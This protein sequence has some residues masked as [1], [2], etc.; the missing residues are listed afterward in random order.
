VTPRASVVVPTYHRPD[1]LEQCLAALCGQSGDLGSYEV[2]VAD[3]AASEATRTQVE[4]WAGRAGNDALRF[5]YVAV[6][7]NHGPAAARNAGWKSATS[8]IIAFT[9]DD[10]LP[11]PGWLAAGVQAISGAAPAATGR[12]VVPLNSNPPT[13]YELDTSHLADAGFITANCFCRRSLLSEVGGFDERFTTAWREDSDLQFKLLARGCAIVHVSDAVVVHPV[14]P[15]PWGVSLR[16]QR[17]VQFNALLYKKHP[18]LYRQRIQRLPPLHYYASLLALIGAVAGG[19]TARRRLSLVGTGVWT[20]LY[21]RF[22]ARRL[23]GTSRRPS[24]IAE[25]AVTSAI[26]P[27]LSIYWRL[28]GALKFRVIFF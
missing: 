14:R 16:Q 13:D 17:K 4:A 10:C 11:E 25:M 1:L 6:R 27:F 5:R 23:R 12:V 18:V 8:D 24:H 26:V 19:L 22:C 9:D 2:I 15:A 28:C 7:G 21:T 3:D 20:L